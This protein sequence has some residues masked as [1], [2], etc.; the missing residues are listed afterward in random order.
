MRPSEPDTVKLR[1]LELEKTVNFKSLRYS[2]I[3]DIEGITLENYRV[4]TY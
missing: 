1:Y 3:R 4:G 2:C